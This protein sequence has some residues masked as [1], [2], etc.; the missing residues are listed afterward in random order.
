MEGSRVVSQHKTE[1]FGSGGNRGSGCRQ[2]PATGSD[3]RTVD[4]VI[5]RQVPEGPEHETH[6]IAGQLALLLD[7]VTDLYRC[8]PPVSRLVKGQ[9]VRQVTSDRHSLPHRPAQL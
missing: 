1:V 4:A 9:E 2:L 6:S 8:R 3:C 5:L 7:C